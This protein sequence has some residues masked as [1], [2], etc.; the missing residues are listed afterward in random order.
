MPKNKIKLKSNNQSID[1]Q[2]SYQQ[3]NLNT[4][5]NTVTDTKNVKQGINQN[6]STTSRP[7]NA[8]YLL[9]QQ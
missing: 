5:R 4:Q 1:V 7:V 8:S 3:I 2:K 9:Q 6:V